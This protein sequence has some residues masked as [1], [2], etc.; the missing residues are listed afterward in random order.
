VSGAPIPLYE[1]YR[2]ADG[3]TTADLS[4]AAVAYFAAVMATLLVL[5]R[6]NHLGRRAVSIA[7]SRRQP[8]RAPS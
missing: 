3:L 1:R 6:S 7:V 8:T 2:H 5:G 4:L